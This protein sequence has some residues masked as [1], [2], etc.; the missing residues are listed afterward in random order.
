[1][2]GTDAEL[3]RRFL[4]LASIFGGAKAEG[5]RL[6]EQFGAYAPAFGMIGTLID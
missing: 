1:M 5:Q 2:D 6:F 4:K 3:V